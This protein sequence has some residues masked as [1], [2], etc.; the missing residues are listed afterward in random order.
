MVIGLPDISGFEIT[1]RIR[2]KEDKSNPT[3][4]VALTAHASDQIQQELVR[5]GIDSY[6]SKPATFDD[7]L[8]ILTEQV[9][10]QQQQRRKNYQAVSMSA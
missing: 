5:S 4:I 8:N 2:Q 10:F 1:K 9:L 7:L 3:V 6:I